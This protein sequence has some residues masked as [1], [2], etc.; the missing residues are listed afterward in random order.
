VRRLPDALFK[1][2]L[3]SLLLRGHDDPAVARESIAVHWRPYAAHDG[4][5][6][7]AGR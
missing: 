2:M 7:M 4:A 5:A 3:A 1:P 6:A